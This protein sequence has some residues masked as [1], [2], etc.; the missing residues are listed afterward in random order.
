MSSTTHTPI[1]AKCDREGFD[2]HKPSI[3]RHIM[4]DSSPIAAQ[5]RIARNFGLS[6]EEVRREYNKWLQS[7]DCTERAAKGFGP[8][9]Y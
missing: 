8:L 9:S 4:H 2:L 6:L 3:M 1:E 7:T 5:A